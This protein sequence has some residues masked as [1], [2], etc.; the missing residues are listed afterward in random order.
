MLTKLKRLG[1]QISEKNRELANLYTRHKM[2]AQGNMKFKANRVNK[3][4]YT[5]EHFIRNL[6]NATRIAFN[7]RKPMTNKYNKAAAK[8]RAIIGLPS[9]PRRGP[10]YPNRLSFGRVK[11]P[12][13]GPLPKINNFYNKYQPVGATSGGGGGRNH[14]S[15]YFGIYYYKFC[16]NIQLMN[17]RLARN[18]AAQTIRQA[19]WRPPKRILLGVG[20]LKGG[21][22]P[23]GGVLYAKTAKKYAKKKN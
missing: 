9:I 1:N 23:G 14:K 15:T 4:A 3:N 22:G 11:R 12:A 13:N 7:E 18:K 16:P 21:L 6:S 19:L 2:N 8:Y 10:P 20:T 17:A 5:N